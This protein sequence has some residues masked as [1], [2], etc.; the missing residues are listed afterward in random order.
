MSKKKGVNDIVV[1]TK[2]KG[3]AMHRTDLSIQFVPNDKTPGQVTSCR[4]R[5]VATVLDDG[6]IG[7]CPTPYKRTT[8]E[9]LKRT[10]HGTLSANENSYYLYVKIDKDG[11]SDFRKLMH[12]EVN[13]LLES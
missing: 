10:L 3:V 2:I 1:V 9:K 5:G 12:N 13:E 11:A 4:R 8:A 7:F 6:T